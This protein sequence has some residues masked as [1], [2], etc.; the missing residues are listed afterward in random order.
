VQATADKTSV[1]EV[2][3]TIKRLH[4]S[5][6]GEV[7]FALQ[8]LYRKV[9]IRASHTSKFSKTYCCTS[10]KSEV[11]ISQQSFTSWIVKLLG[12]TAH[13][14]IT[15]VLL[16]LGVLLHITLTHF[17]PRGHPPPKASVVAD[18]IV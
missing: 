17:T 8:H 13:C 9:S 16:D 12:F 11:Y 15:S 2:I 5:G 7:G 3:D 14:S 4:T 10:H 6:V 18:I 1:E